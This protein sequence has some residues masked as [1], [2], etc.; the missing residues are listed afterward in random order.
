MLTEDE[1]AN[2]LA[3]AIVLYDKSDD[4]WFSFRDDIDIN[5]YVENDMV[6]VTAY[7]YDPETHELNTN[8]YQPL[9]VQQINVRSTDDSFSSYE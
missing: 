8:K 6:F 4:G 7:E 2:A 1:I 9:L 5:V 3:M